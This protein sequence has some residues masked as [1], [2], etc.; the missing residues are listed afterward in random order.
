M[1][2]IR[3]SELQ[4][5][6]LLSCTHSILLLFS[7]TH[8]VFLSVALS[9]HLSLP[10]ISHWYTLEACAVWAVFLQSV[11]AMELFGGL[12][13]APLLFWG[14]VHVALLLDCPPKSVEMFNSLS[15]CAEDFRFFPFSF[16][17]SLLDT[18]LHLAL[19]PV[20]RWMKTS[21]SQCL[22]NTSLTMTEGIM[23]DKEEYHN[24]VLLIL[25]K[26]FQ[27]LHLG[28]FYHES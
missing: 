3:S 13:V 24:V 10:C 22:V 28:V 4:A 26:V 12:G 15:F 25:K 18:F 2:N 5:F 21:I 17:A 27:N 6:I 7:L 14:L 16:S 11:D 23:K 8:C 1:Q 20:L 19:F 9:F